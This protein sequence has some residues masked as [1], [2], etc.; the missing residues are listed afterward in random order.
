MHARLY[1][2]VKYANEKY[3]AKTQKN[4]WAMMMTWPAMGLKWIRYEIHKSNSMYPTQM[5][6]KQKCFKSIFQL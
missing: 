4:W 6:I 1:V 5:R 2:K 3:E